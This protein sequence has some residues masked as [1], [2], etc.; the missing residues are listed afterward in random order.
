[1][2]LEPR[3][4]ILDEPTAALDV[5]VQLVILQLLET[6]KQR[7]GMSYLFV[8]HDLNVVR[9]LCE[10]RRHCEEPQ[11]T[12]Q[13]RPIERALTGPRLL[14]CARNDSPTA[15]VRSDRKL[16]LNSATYARNAR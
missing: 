12:K 16:R 1:V 6:L 2:A 11:A 7:L 8:S 15:P 4:L 14:R 13:S 9:L 5:S 10:S 3:L